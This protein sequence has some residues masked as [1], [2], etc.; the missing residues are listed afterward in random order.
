MLHPGAPSFCGTLQEN[1]IYI[2]DTKNVKNPYTK[3]FSVSI[4]FI[5]QKTT[6]AKN[7]FQIT[8]GDMLMDNLRKG[9]F[10]LILMKVSLPHFIAEQEKVKFNG[11][12]DIF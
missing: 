10:S 2:G 6:K 4:K 12:S 3:L 1:L 8:Y 5:F 11:M 9:C 7:K